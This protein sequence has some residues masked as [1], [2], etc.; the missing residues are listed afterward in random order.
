MPNYW[1]IKSDLNLDAAEKLKN[2]PNFHHAPSISRSYYACYLRI[3]HV[4]NHVVGYDEGQF[5]T[6]F[7]AYKAKTQGGKH[8]FSIHMIWDIMK[9]KNL[10]D[11]TDFRNEILALKKLRTTAD[12]RNELQEKDVSDRAYTKADAVIKILR[13]QF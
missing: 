6:R 12:Y 5:N 2:S 11:A 8:D 10:K 7:N 13:R 9:T 4:I 1:L 3:I